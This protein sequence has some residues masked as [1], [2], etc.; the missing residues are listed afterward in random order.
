MEFMNLG[1]I[2]LFA[3]LDRWEITKMLMG[4]LIDAESLGNKT[5][6]TSDWYVDIGSKVCIFL[7]MSSFLKNVAG[8]LLYVLLGCRRIVDR[9]CKSDLKNDPED[10]EDDLP[11][12]KQKI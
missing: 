3:S 2:Q 8:I 6:F 5:D 12:T 10:P 1:I 11:N 4:R 7:F 9:G